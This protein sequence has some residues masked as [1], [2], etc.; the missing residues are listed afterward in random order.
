MEAPLF[1]QYWH[2]WCEKMAKI[3]IFDSIE[4]NECSHN[5]NAFDD[6]FFQQQHTAFFARFTRFNTFSGRNP[7]KPH[8]SSSSSGIKF[9]H[10]NWK[11]KYWFKLIVFIAFWSARWLWTQTRPKYTQ[12]GF[13]MN[14]KQKSGISMNSPNNNNGL[15]H[16]HRPTFHPIRLD[17]LW[18]YCIIRMAPPIPIDSF[19]FWTV[20]KSWISNFKN[21]RRFSIPIG[22]SYRI[23]NT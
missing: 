23:N 11:Q 5:L 13:R 9:E 21:A 14:N 10:S 22:K 20:K 7:F 12:N 17:Y 18:S 6:F 19:Y 1:L 15:W 4:H 3:S 8:S 16:C 2:I